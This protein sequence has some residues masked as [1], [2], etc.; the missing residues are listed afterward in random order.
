VGL[1]ICGSPLDRDYERALRALARDGANGLVSFLGSVPHPEVLALMRSAT[2]T[3]VPSRVENPSRVPIEAVAAMSP[4][5]AADLPVFRES[6]G[7]AALFYPP[8]DPHAL[9]AA[10][11]R[12]LRDDSL[13]RDLVAAASARHAGV[14]WLS[15]TRVILETLELM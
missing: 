3:L 7:E 6:C 10:M 14:D 2:A 5:V 13:R 15:A 11:E 8:G 12:L 9:A 4:I 1:L